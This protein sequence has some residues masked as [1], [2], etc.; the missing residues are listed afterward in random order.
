MVRRHGNTG[1]CDQLKQMC[2]PVNHLVR[3]SGLPDVKI[4][5]SVILCWYCSRHVWWGRGETGTR[6]VDSICCR[7]EWCY[8]QAY[9]TAQR[10]GCRA[11]KAA[12]WFNCWTVHICR[13]GEN[14]N[15]HV[16]CQVHKANWREQRLTLP[17]SVQEVR[18]MNLKQDTD[19]PDCLSWFTSVLP[20]WWLR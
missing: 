15:E 14:R 18:S 10:T 19:V 3:V 9:L 4:G 8:R 5:S 2:V 13:P 1:Y 12:S 6:P 7:S 20:S 16:T 11:T 17:T